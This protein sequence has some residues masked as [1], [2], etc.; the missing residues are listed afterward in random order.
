M[1]YV[2]IK[3]AVIIA[4][5]CIPAQGAQAL[6]PIELQDNVYLLSGIPP[7]HAFITGFPQSALSDNV[8]NFISGTP[9]TFDP[10]GRPA[11]YLAFSNFDTAVEAVRQRSGAA[12]IY[13]YAI[14]GNSEWYDASVTIRAITRNLAYGLIAEEADDRNLTIRRR[15][16]TPNQISYSIEYIYGQGGMLWWNNPANGYLHP[17]RSYPPT[18]EQRYI[19]D[20]GLHVV[21]GSMPRLIAFNTECDI[22]W[23][24][25][26]ITASV[27][28]ATHNCNASDIKKLS[29]SQ[30][31]AHLMLPMLFDANGN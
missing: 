5:A 28:N 25:L 16:I 9:P 31:A 19:P 13:L 27:L 21:R 1:P 23:L 29:E 24:R 15:S 26:F 30:Y 17:G 10:S 22:G 4:L 11:F 7:D 20:R 8:Q 6:P 12:P 2:K 14:A 3:L 18:S